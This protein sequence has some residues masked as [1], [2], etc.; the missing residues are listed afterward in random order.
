M[1]YFLDKIDNYIRDNGIPFRNIEIDSD[2]LP[3]YFNYAIL[4]K[5]RKL[6]LYSFDLMWPSKYILTYDDDN[7]LYLEAIGSDCRTRLFVYSTDG[8]ENASDVDY[9]TKISDYQLYKEAC[10]IKYNKKIQDEM[11]KKINAKYSD[12]SVLDKIK[13]LYDI[14]S[15][16]NHEYTF[17]MGERIASTADYIKEMDKA[18]DSIIAYINYLNTVYK[19]N[20]LEYDREKLVTV[21]FTIPDNDTV[22]RKNGDGTGNGS[23]ERINKVIPTN[24]RVRVLNSFDYDYYCLASNGSNSKIDYYC[25]LYRNYDDIPILVIESYSGINYTRVIYLKRGYNYSKEEFSN[26]CKRYLELSNC[27][28]FQT[29]RVIRFNHTNI[30]DFNS[31]IKLVIEGTSRKKD[32]D[33]CRRVKKIMNNL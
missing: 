21:N 26:L 33:K 23:R 6:G 14:T 20:L 12:K 3:L 11:M 7:N 18:S 15:V 5:I 31:N 24:D 2:Y 32:Y 10:V 17:L 16:I 27:D 25:Y 19:D 9:R 30:E 4:C 1:F 28:S 13:E 22:I 8:Y 29:G